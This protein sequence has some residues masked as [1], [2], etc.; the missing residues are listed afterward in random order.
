MCAWLS[1]G[2]LFA[3]LISG[4]RIASGLLSVGFGVNLLY[5]FDFVSGLFSAH[6]QRT[7]R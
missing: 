3:Y 7:R 6:P 1:A 5:R 2:R 4:L